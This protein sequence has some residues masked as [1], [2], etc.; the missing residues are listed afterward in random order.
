M[1]VT[2]DS[3]QSIVRDVTVGGVERLPNGHLKRTYSGKP[4]TLCPT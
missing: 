4:P 1:V 3:E 2:L